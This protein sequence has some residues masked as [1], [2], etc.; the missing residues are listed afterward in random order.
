[1]EVPPISDPPAPVDQSPNQGTPSD[2]PTTPD[3][4]STPSDPDERGKDEITITG[5]VPKERH[6]NLETTIPIVET[7][8]EIPTVID[9][10]ST[11]ITST[12]TMKDVVTTVPPTPIY[13]TPDVATLTDSNGI[14]TATVTSTPGPISTPTVITTTDNQGRPTVITT[15][16]LATV[17]VSTLTDSNGVP[18]ATQTFYPSMPT[19]QTRVI[20][21]RMKRRDYV[22]GFFLPTIL[23]VLLAI[24]IRMID[25]NVQLYY[26]FHELTRA[27]GAPASESMLLRMG[28]IFGLQTAWRALGQKKML[29]FLSTLLVWCSAI[30][31]PL[32]TEAV[33]LKLYSL[34]GKCSIHNFEGCMMALAV[35][36]IPA[37]ATMA[38]LAFMIVLLCFIMISLRKWQSGVAHNP[39]SIAGMAAL[40]TNPQTRSAIAGLP[41]RIKD[42]K[43]SRMRE[44]LENKNFRLGY[45]VNA[46]GEVE[47]GV[48]IHSESTPLQAPNPGNEDVWEFD[49][50]TK[51][52]KGR[53]IRNRL[54]F[55]MLSVI[56]RLVFG[57]F[58]AGLLV[59]ILYYR[60]TGGET[61]FNQF[62]SS[63]TFGVRFLFTCFGVIINFFWSSIFEGGYSY[64][65]RSSEGGL[66]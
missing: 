11:T 22:V 25:L 56:G 18:T 41:T 49:E 26:P 43:Y 40:T 2:D 66:I 23:S 27:D 4:P 64:N 33:A 55:L 21:I 17:S 20:V 42:I 35:F 15:D 57:L 6:G 38:L 3:P 52:K 39:W 31:I 12:S 61:G 28:G 9:G 24:P 62:M 19:S 14:P 51:G 29:P 48:M 16:V 30:L 7:P 50:M 53:R 63:S 59:L 1:M 60:F 8:V 13:V 10:K 36:T 34:N 5:S 58:L 45:F 37:R 47:Y 65:D 46:R 54:P 32:S 44:Y